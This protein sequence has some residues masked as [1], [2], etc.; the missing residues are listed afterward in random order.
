MNYFPIIRG[1]LYDLAAFTTLANSQRLP[2]TVIPVLEP[3]KDIPGLTKT[4]QALTKTAHAAYVIQ[5]PQVGSYRLLATPRHLPMLSPSVQVARIFDAQPAPLIIATTAA[6]AKLLARRQLA[7]VPDEAR[8]R[9]LGL[10]H[11]VYLND[12][13][14]VY[15][16]TSAY[17][18]LQDEFYQY[19]LDMLPGVGFADYP[20][21]TSDYFEHGFPQRALAIHLVYPATDGSLRLHH[22]VS[23]NNE[24]FTNPQAKFFEILT[25]LAAWL[26]YHPQAQTAGVTAL[27]KAAADHHFPGLGVVRKFQLMHHLEMIGRWLQD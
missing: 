21:A 19:S 24:D 20:L 26:P 5:N 13:F 4:T 12:H 18:L 16:H 15:S 9:R 3:V 1:K 17:G 7:L 23:V 25:Q 10:R 11:A 8:V 2:A 22:F 6:Q 14:T 27:M